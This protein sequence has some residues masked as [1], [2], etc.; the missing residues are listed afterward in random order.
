MGDGAGPEDRLRLWANAG[1]GSMQ[2]DV[3][4]PTD[5]AGVWICFW[6]LTRVGTPLSATPTETIDAA[7]STAGA[8]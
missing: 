8:N 1:P 4:S 7:V 5:A 2:G 3:P 6:L